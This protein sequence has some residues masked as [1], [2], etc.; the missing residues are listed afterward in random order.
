MPKRNP[1]KKSA[2]YVIQSP[3]KNSDRK[4]RGTIIQLLTKN[5]MNENSLQKIINTKNNRLK[6]ILTK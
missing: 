2:G 6:R 4:I 1:S 3:F 5:P